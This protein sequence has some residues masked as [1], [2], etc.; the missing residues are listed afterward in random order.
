MLPRGSSHRPQQRCD[1]LHRCR[2]GPNVVPRGRKPSVK[3]RSF[4]SEGSKSTPAA[5]GISRGICPY[6][7]PRRP[8]LQNGQFRPHFLTDRRP[9]LG[10]VSPSETGPNRGAVGVMSSTSSDPPRRGVWQSICTRDVTHISHPRMRNLSDV[11]PLRRPMPTRNNKII[12]SCCI[13][14]SSSPRPIRK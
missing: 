5:P 11:V 8:K 3:N 4:F 13:E 2:G 7:R 6:F 1:L 14:S 9:D 12:F 10:V